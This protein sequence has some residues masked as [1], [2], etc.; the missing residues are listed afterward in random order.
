MVNAKTTCTLAGLTDHVKIIL[1]LRIIC[2]E[3]LLVKIGAITFVVI[4]IKTGPR[5]LSVL[6]QMTLSQE[7]DKTMIVK[8]LITTTEMG[9]HSLQITKVTGISRSGGLPTDIIKWGRCYTQLELWRMINLLLV[10]S[11]ANLLLYLLIPAHVAQY[12]AKLC[13]KDGFKKHA[14]V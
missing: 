11:M 2:R 7:V 14:Q 5:R 6:V 9:L 12:S 1:P 10:I 3:G 8:L 13:L 4:L